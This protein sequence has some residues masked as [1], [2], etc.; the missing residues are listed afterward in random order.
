MPGKFWRNRLNKVLSML[1]SLVLAFF[2]WLALAGQDTSTVDLT[3][4]LELANLPIDLAIKSEVPGSATVQ[5]SA[6]TA[7][8]RFLADRKLHLKLDVSL[9]KEG[10][11]TFQLTD[12]SLDLPRGVQLRKITPSM[13]E[14]EAAKLANKTVPVKTVIT[15][16]VNM[17]YRL[18]SLIV[19]PTHVLL[20]GPQ[21]AIEGVEQIHTAPIVLD[22][23]TQNQ[24]MSVNLSTSDLAAGLEV[25]PREV[26]AAINVEEIV[27]ERTFPGLPV[28]ID[29]KS[30]GP[31]GSQIS[32]TPER[33]SVSMT[34]PALRMNPITSADI[35]AKVYVDDEKLRKEGALTLQIVVVPPD[36]TTV[37]A[38]DP[39]NATVT[40]IP[41]KDPEA[42]PEQ[43]AGRS[44]AP[45]ATQ[46][47]R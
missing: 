14:F 6:N 2:L 40:Y 20:R 32:V 3:V 17:A 11:N 4:P 13:I 9:A 43:P 12:E 28:E 22:G 16:R 33:V 42:A 31:N 25:S 27:E 21:D 23:I 1:V 10:G 37:T 24:T 36:G 39:P 29:R 5:V 34:W 15:G 18:K 7:Q 8:G 38:I 47:G 45:P 46:E 19:D 44:A 26:M 30:G 41:P 35:K